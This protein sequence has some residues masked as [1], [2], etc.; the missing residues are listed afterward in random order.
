[1][2]TLRVSPPKTNGLRYQ[3]QCGA[4]LPGTNVRFDYHALIGNIGV[5]VDPVKLFGGD[6]HKKHLREE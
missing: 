3:L 4:A 1:M 5:G 6:Q 2:L